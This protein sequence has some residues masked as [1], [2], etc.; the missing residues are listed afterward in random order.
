MCKRATFK[1]KSRRGVS[2]EECFAACDES[3]ENLTGW[4]FDSNFLPPRQSLARR[5]RIQIFKNKFFKKAPSN[6]FLDFYKPFRVVYFASLVIFWMSLLFSYLY[7]H[8]GLPN[9]WNRRLFENRRLFKSAG[10]GSTRRRRR[11][12]RDKCPVQPGRVQ[13]VPTSRTMSRH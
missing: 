8:S 1:S 7:K 11:C 10:R 3:R 2:K 12:M 5:N 6:D 4:F 13:D 9:H